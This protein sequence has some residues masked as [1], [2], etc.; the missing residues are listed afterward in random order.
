MDM[1]CYKCIH[2]YI[3]IYIY[4]YILYIH[5]YIYIYHT[6]SRPQTCLSS[7]KGRNNKR[8][9]D[10]GG[11]ERGE[12]MGE[13]GLGG[14]CGFAMAMGNILEA[15]EMPYAKYSHTSPAK[16]KRSMFFGVLRNV[17][18]TRCD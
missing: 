11:D 15:G 16:C 3:C 2:I 4:L 14:N 7:E 1:V 12:I 9:R 18:E 8:E 5:I 17:F 13:G 10:E 6:H